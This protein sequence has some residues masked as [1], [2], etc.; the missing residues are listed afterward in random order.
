MCRTSRS[1]RQ[2]DG[3]Q[4]SVQ[5]RPAPRSGEE[6][7]NALLGSADDRGIALDDY[8]AL[9]QSLTFDEQIDDGIGITDVVLGVEPQFL[10]LRVLADKILDRILETRDEVLE[11]RPVG[12]FLHVDHDLM[13]DTQV[14]GDRQGVLGRT[15]M[16]VVID[17]HY[18]HVIVLPRW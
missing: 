10:E 2:N 14:L 4:S 3:A 11:R 16:R 8:R 7:A 1:S 6:R 9:E 12:R 18:S 13:V 5:E 17:G 15:S